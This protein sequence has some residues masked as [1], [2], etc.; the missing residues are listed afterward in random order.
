MLWVVE[1]QMLSCL[2]G[3]DIERQLWYD[4]QYTQ[5]RAYDTCKNQ[6]AMIYCTVAD[7]SSI[8]T[9]II[10]SGLRRRRRRRRGGKRR[11]RA[12]CCNLSMRRGGGWL[13]GGG[14]RS[15]G[16]AGKGRHTPPER[17]A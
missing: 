8:V 11:D 16:M 12:K 4:V 15:L 7:K 6:Y 9:C 13:G 17:D 3:G 2:H 1:E 10:I 14:G 5:H